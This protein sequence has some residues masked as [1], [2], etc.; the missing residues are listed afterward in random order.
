VNHRAAL[1][2]TYSAWLASGKKFPL[3]YFEAELGTQ[4]Q[5]FYPTNYVIVSSVEDRNH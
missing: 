1:L 2:L 4:T 5:N 3:S